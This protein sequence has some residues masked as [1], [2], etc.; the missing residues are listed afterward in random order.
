[1]YICP[2]CKKGFN[3]SE[4]VVKHYLSC[5]KERNPNHSSKEAP[6]SNDVITRKINST[7]EDFFRRGGQNG[8][9]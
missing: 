8:T 6:H 2:V 7:M 4:I 9:K 1:M 3:S 5:W